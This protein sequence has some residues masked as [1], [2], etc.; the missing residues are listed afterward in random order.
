MTDAKPAKRASKAV[1]TVRDAASKAVATTTSTTRAATEKAIAGIEANPIAILSGGIALGALIGAFAP[2]SAAERKILRPVG[3]RLNETAR[4][5]VDAAR[6][7]ARAEF[8]VLGLSR[9]AALKRT[10]GYYRLFMAPGM[11]HCTGGPGPDLFDALTPL[12]LWVEQ[13]RTP[14]W[15]IARHATNGRIDNERPLCPFPQIA[16]WKGKGSTTNAANFICAAA[17]R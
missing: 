9:D 12:R 1:A 16:R 7:T 15:I 14:E 10:R 11:Q 17:Q 8:D 2:R 5:A 6:D 13:K 3:K 4:G